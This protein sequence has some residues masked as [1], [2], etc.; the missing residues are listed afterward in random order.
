MGDRARGSTPDA[1]KSISVYN[2]SPMSTQPGHPSVGRRNDYQ[3]KSGDV[4]RL[5]W[6]VKADM[7]REWVAGKTVWSSCYHG[8]YL[9][10]SSNGL[11]PYNRALYKCP[12]TL[13]LTLSVG[14]FHHACHSIGQAGSLLLRFPFP[15]YPSGIIKG[16]ILYMTPNQ[17][18][19]STEGVLLTLLHRSF[20]PI[21]LWEQCW[22]C[23][24]FGFC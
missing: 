5:W 22:K 2:Q 18:C 24:A 10:V 15:N 19:C 21:P 16:H 23:Y 7:V 13:T 11:V 20:M 1:G 4:M 12:I 17:H 6:G 8:P 14:L 9:S 3:S